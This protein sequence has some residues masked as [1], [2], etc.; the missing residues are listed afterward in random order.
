MR[1]PLEVSKSNNQNWGMPDISEMF[2]R[3]LRNPFS[4]LDELRPT[5][6]AGNQRFQPHFDVD[7]T[8]QAYLV[9]VDLPGMKKEDIKLDLSDN[10]LTISG[11]RKHEQ[12][13]KENGSRRYERS[14]GRFQRSF[15][16]PNTVMVDKV[17]ADLE[18]G[19][20]RIA[21]PKTEKSSSRT[22]EV[23]SG[24][25]SSFFQKQ[26]DSLQAASRK[27]DSKSSKSPMAP[28]RGKD[29]AVDQ[30]PQQSRH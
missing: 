3:M 19:V 7:E 1:N 8:D 4:M 16:L 28:E 21:L 26:P 14:Y 30:Q 12:S 18:D 2:E 15:T 6:L 23:Q 5:L 27:Q 17:E 20:L 9:N 24:R 10:I 11:E 25:Q 13:S 29:S 22:I